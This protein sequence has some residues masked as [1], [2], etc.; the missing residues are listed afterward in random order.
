M[1]SPVRRWVALSALVFAVLLVAIDATVLGLAMPLLTED[2]RPSAVELLWIGDVYGFVL[3]GLLVTMGTLGDRIGRK[4]LLLIGT[5]AFGLASLLA[6]FAPSSELLIAGRALLGI[7]GATLMPSTL[8]LIRNIFTDRRERTMAIGMWSAAASAGAAAGPLIGGLLLEHFWWGSVFL[9]NVPVMLIVLVL[10]AV[11]LPESRDPNPGR[12]D[13][14]SVLLSMVGAIGV[15]YAIKEIA[16]YGL[17]NL[18]GWVAGAVGVVALI[19]FARRQRRLTTPLLDIQL[20]ANPRF[21]GAI[22][23]D[24][25]AVFGL[26]GLAFFLS[27]YFQLVRGYSPLW[28]GLA[29]L[30]AAVGAVLG[31]LLAAPLV[32]R[33]SSRVVVSGGLGLVAVGLGSLLFLSLETP[34]VPIGVVLLVFGFGAGLAMTVTAEVIM[35]SVRKE[36]AGA[37]SAVSETAYELGGAL[38]LAILGTILM[39]VYRSGIAGIPADSLAPPAAHAAADSIGGAVTVAAGLPTEV[40]GMLMATA[41]E[42]FVDGL[43]YASVGAAVLLAASAVLTWFLLRERKTEPDQPVAKADAPARP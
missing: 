17:G 33:T 27:Q 18:P 30:P 14:L 36:K 6:A 25:L 34:Y 13:L 8:S 4:R 20:F 23:G 38:G 40:A 3:A 43:R 24:L 19:A 1:M 21:T 11:L 31:G 16:A 26:T 7:A 12:W 39:A 22:L 37:A 32:A 2:L 29:E 10:G 41:R 15:V 35:S 9:I 28:A 5:T 42:S